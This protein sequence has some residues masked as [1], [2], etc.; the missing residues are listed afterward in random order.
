MSL[1]LMAVKNTCKRKDGSLLVE[2]VQVSNLDVKPRSGMYCILGTTSPYRDPPKTRKHDNGKRLQ[3]KKGD[4]R[5][6]RT[7]VLEEPVKTAIWREEFSFNFQ[8]LTIPNFFHLELWQT[9]KMSKDKLFGYIEI[10]ISG[11]FISDGW[12]SQWCPMDG[13]KILNIEA[14]LKFKLEPPFQGFEK[15]SLSKEQFTDIPSFI[16]E[17]FWVPRYLKELSLQECGLESVTENIV[18]LNH[19]EYINLSRNNIAKLPDFLGSM[20]NLEIFDLSYNQL[21]ELPPSIKDLKKLQ[22]LNLIENKFTSFPD[23]L[24]E[25]YASEKGIIRITTE[26]RHLEPTETQL[27][28]YI[29][30]NEEQNVLAL[31]DSLLTTELEEEVQEETG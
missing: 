15:I 6:E 28:G 24:L 7:K 20:N 5:L 13:S 17:S 16:F 22:E 14:H 9:R 30:K 25:M 3:E 27:L 31:A 21:S 19:L 18:N 11:S 23:V 4:V 2:V 12:V 26:G 1:A 10:P 8:D 29:K